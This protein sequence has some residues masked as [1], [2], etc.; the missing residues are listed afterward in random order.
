MK[1]TIATG[2]FLPVPPAAGGATEKIW[3][4]LSQLFAAAG[5]EVTFVSRSWPGFPDQETLNGVRHLRLRGA[6]HTRWLALNLWHDFWWGRRVARALPAADVTVC[7]LV[8]LPVSLRRL[9][10]DAGRVVAVMARMPKGQT[11]FYDQVD[12]LLSLSPAVTA[13]IVSENPSLASR[14]A[15]FPFPIDWSLHAAA[16]AHAHHATPIT[17]GYIGRLHPEKGIPLLLSAAAELATRSDLPP[18]RLQLLGPATIAAGG[19]GQAWIDALKAKFSAIL[20]DRLSIL[21]AEFDP[22]LLA[23]R[24][25]AIDV[26]CYPSL[27]EKGETFGVAIAEAMAAGG[28]PVVSQLACF[29]PLVIPGS[30]GLVFDHTAPSAKTEFSHCLA[31]LLADSA[32][33]R[34]LSTSAQEHVRQFDYPEIARTVSAEFARLASAPV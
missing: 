8:S 2:F 7:N 6:S 10:P 26:F 4:R 14:I 9:R 27:A 15:P 18:W 34:R 22:E 28:V 17:L 11:R 23:Q 32:L 33:R 16:G 5:H 29:N 3:H 12:L 20:G 13:K 1:I 24:Y 25:A 31:Q 30:T 21:P 19:A